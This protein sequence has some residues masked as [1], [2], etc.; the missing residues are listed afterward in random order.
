MISHHLQNF[1][2]TTLETAT[3]NSEFNR[4]VLEDCDL[5]QYE[6]FDNNFQPNVQTDPLEDD[7]NMIRSVSMTFSRS[8]EEYHQTALKCYIDPKN[9][10]KM[11]NCS[12]KLFKKRDIVPSIDNYKCGQSF[13]CL[14]SYIQDSG[15]FYVQKTTRLKD[16]EHLEDCIQK[17]ANILIEDS[18]MINEL[19]AFQ[20]NCAK[21]DVVL[22]KAAWDSKWHR[23]IFLGNTTSSAI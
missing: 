7:F 12:F 19:Y 8:R 6:G 13:E 10:N 4:S 16:L 5:T 3:H 15:Q 17:Y 20:E 23:A 11:F 22:V 1:N 18:S 14:I 21:F 9:R 2:D